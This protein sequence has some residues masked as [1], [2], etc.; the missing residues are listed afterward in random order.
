LR[1]AHADLREEIEWH[2]EYRPE[3]DGRPDEYE[4]HGIVGWGRSRRLGLFRDE[5]HKAYLGVQHVDTGSLGWR[6][7]S[8]PYARFFFS[9]FQGKV[10][11]TLQ[12]YQT[13]DACLAALSSLLDLSNLEKEC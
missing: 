9:L 10:C 12:T 8:D 2:R 13:M 1:I 4:R 7:A 11:Q 5:R 6:S 3:W